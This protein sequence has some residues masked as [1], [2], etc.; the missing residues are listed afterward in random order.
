MEEVLAI[1]S[2]FKAFYSSIPVLEALLQMFNVAL[3][4]HLKVSS[5]EALG[6][7]NVD[8]VVF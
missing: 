7:Q 6:T 8:S 3:V 2:W 1:T 4:V 5:V